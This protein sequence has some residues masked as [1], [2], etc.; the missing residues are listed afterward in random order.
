MTTD[1]AACALERARAAWGDLPDWVEALARACDDGSQAAIARKLDVSPALVSGVL[2][3]T[4][5]G[6]MAA[7]EQRV[8]GA[9][10]AKT[11][12]CPVVGDLAADACLANQRAPWSSHNPGRISFF[13]ACRGGC[14]HAIGGVDADGTD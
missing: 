13:R 7:V 9:L 1:A 6:S 5:K 4:Y 2:R 12:A 8:R 14:P 11:V 3:K 10:L